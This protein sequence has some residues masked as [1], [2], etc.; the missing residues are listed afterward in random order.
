MDTFLDDDDEPHVADHPMD[1][2]E[3]VLAHD[4]RIVT[5]RSDDGD[6][7][8]TCQGAWC[9]VTGFLGWREEL[10]AVLLTASFDITAPAARMTEA[11]RLI[12]LIN[13][14]L[15]LGHFDLW[16]EDGSIVFRHSIPMIGRGDL[17]TGE[18]HALVAASMDAADR[19][20]PAFDFLLRCGQT[21][22][23]SLRI[24]LFETIGEA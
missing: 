4:A 23:E 11:A 18:V 19:F 8:F 2:A 20:F 22:E 7:S 17:T 24:A 9:S 12:A 21:A 14:N 10:P 5:E 3:A 16:A 13:E 15:W 1:I 6:L